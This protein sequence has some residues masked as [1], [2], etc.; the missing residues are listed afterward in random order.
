[1]LITLDDVNDLTH[2]LHHTLPLDMRDEINLSLKSKKEEAVEY[3]RE[4]DTHY[5]FFSNCSRGGVCQGGITDWT[6]AFS[7]ANLRDRWENYDRLWCS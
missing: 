5:A 2:G 3:E 4:G 1:M 7:M 6:D